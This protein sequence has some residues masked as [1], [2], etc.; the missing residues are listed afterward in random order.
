MFFRFIP[1]LSRVF[2]GG[3]QA[4]KIKGGKGSFGLLL[5][6]F[7]I[8]DLPRGGFGF[9]F[10]GAAFGAGIGERAFRLIGGVPGFR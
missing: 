7:Q 9:A 6:R 2:S 4:I 1:R 3:G 10:G 8:A 5:P